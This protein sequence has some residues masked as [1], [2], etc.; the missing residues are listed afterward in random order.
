MKHLRETFTDQE[1][2][3]LKQP[4]ELADMSWHVFLLTASQ[5]FEVCANCVKTGTL[6]VPEDLRNLLLYEVKE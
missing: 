3:Q 2:E 1:F 4:K 6:K 5:C